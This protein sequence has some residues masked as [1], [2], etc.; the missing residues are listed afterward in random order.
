MTK[1]DEKLIARA[2]YIIKVSDRYMTTEPKITMDVLAF[3]LY[4][5]LGDEFYKKIK[6]EKES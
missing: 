4:D 3:I 6:K 1:K 2:E 5:F